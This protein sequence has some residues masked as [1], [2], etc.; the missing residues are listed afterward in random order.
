MKT[1]YSAEY[2]TKFDILFRDAF[3]ALM[4][5]GVDMT[6]ELNQLPDDVRDNPQYQTFTS[7]EEYFTRIGDLAKLHSDQVDASDDNEG[8]AKYSKFL[9]LPL[10]EIHG[11]NV[12]SI[13]PNA[14]SINIPSSYARNGVSI[15]GDELAETLLFEIDRFFDTTDL[16]TT[17]IYVQWTNPAGVAGASKITMVD[18][19]SKPGKLVFGW[20]LTSK[21][22]VEGKDPLRFSVRFFKR[23]GDLIT[24]SLNTLPA[25]VQIKQ[26]LYTNWDNTLTIDD[27]AAELKVAIENGPAS[28][29]PEALVPVIYK[30][31]TALAYL[32]DGP[33]DEDPNGVDL[34][35]RSVTQDSGVRSYTW[36]FKPY[37]IEDNQV[38]EGSTQ[39]IDKREQYTPTS[40]TEA[41]PNKKYYYDLGE[42]GYKA[43]DPSTDTFVKEGLYEPCSIYSVHWKE[44]DHV[45]GIYSVEAL[46]RV[47][48]RQSKKESATT[49]I[50]Y[51]TSVVFKENEN[52]KSD[53]WLTAENGILDNKTL[54]VGTTA[55]PTQCETVYKWEYTNTYNGTMA[56]LV[57]TDEDG[58]TIPVSTQASLDTSTPGWYRVTA[59]SS[60]NKETM[61]KVSDVC[62]VLGPIEAPVISPAADKTQPIIDIKPEEDKATLK[63]TAEEMGG[64]LKSDSITYTWYRNKPNENEIEVKET[65]ADVISMK[66]GE[67]EVKLLS[68]DPQ[69]IE[70][71]F[72][73]VT[74]H[75]ADKTASSTSALFTIA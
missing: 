43:F 69:G 8:Y 59:Y 61:Y 50:P 47:G 42:G 13:D 71:F 68:T 36:Y 12:F 72:C 11:N 28:D 23:K 52:L 45:T 64:L 6:P 56:E 31:L 60:L 57:T 62:R 40:D 54:R 74:N 44:G 27:P 49:L 55:T 21:V 24:Y 17:D 46:N 63:V 16:V 48:K 53:E 4:D 10:D 18:Y 1:V 33:T 41:K 2:S 22:T 26:A 7:L 75:L 38:V 30:D 14:R 58:A 32:N 35:V 5:G 34:E 9:M 15:T 65:D 19:N 25:S 66:D 37:Y 3:K 70:F 73:V 29:G 51:P 39:T 20:P 67:L